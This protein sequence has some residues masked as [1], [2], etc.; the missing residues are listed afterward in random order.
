MHTK[1]PYINLVNQEC[2]ENCLFNDFI[3]N[4]CILDYKDDNNKEENIKFNDY[5]L[6]NFE[7]YLTSEEYNT[8]KLEN[9]QDDIYEYEK[10]TIT[11]TTT[12]NQRNNTYKNITTIDLGECEN[13]LKTKYN[14]PEN[15]ILYVKK[16]D[17]IQEGMKIPKVEYDVYY[18]FP[19]NNSL[20]KLD[21]S[22]CKDTKISLLMPVEISESLDILNSS[23]KYYNDICYIAS[24]D[25]GTDIILKDR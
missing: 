2:V 13:I 1:K 4:Q 7:T 11:M 24:S 20:E 18:K 23:S 14:I 5:I 22:L 25:D 8:S 12:Q 3:S 21:L 15:D 9:N 16:I 19:N 10:M 6:H 17:I